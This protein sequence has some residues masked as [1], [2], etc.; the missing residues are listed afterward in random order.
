MSVQVFINNDHDYLQWMADNPN[1]FVV[2]TGRT[3]RSTYTSLHTSGCTHIVEYE[4]LANTKSRA[5]VC[6][7]D[8]DELYYWCQENRPAIGRFHHLCTSCK[9]KFEEPVLYPDE[10]VDT[11]GTIF[12]GAKEQVAVNRYERSSKERA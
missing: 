6:S 7:N 10:I 1:G 4:G 2:N 11:S 3:K 12:E 9:P 8:P 5:K